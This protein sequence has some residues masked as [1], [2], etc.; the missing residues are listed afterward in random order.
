MKRAKRTVTSAHVE[1]A[2]TH[3]DPHAYGAR[4]QWCAG[5]S[6]RKFSEGGLGTIV[7]QPIGSV[8]TP[9]EGGTYVL[10]DAL[11]EPMA[12]FADDL[13]LT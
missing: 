5:T 4:V 12:C 6:M 7:T 10:W 9:P 11:R 2:G 3:P 1:T 13:E 8:G